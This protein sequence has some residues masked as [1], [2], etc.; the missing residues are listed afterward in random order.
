MFVRSKSLRICY[1]ISTFAKSNL[2][3]EILSDK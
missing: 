3:V 1:Q 2:E